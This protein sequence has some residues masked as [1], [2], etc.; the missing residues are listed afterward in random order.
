MPIE[1]VARYS[2]DDL[3]RR[4]DALFVFGDNMK[5]VGMGGQAKACRGEPN[6]IG[7]PTKW[8]PSMFPSAF[9]K[10]VD[11]ARVRPTLD[12]VFDRLQMHLQSGGTVV[13]PA[14]GVGTGLAEL[15]TRAPAI[16]AYITDRIAQLD[17]IAV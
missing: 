1:K 10:D 6:A 15:P 2:R 14:D 3:R 4:P 9:F 8:S 7:I 16:H 11:L 5:R 17:A 12:R 13:L